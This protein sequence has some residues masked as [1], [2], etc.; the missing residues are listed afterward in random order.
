MKRSRLGAKLP[1][2]N[3]PKLCRVSLSWQAFAWASTSPSYGDTVLH[4]YGGCQPPMKRPTADAATLRC[5]LSAR[6]SWLCSEVSIFIQVP[7]GVRAKQLDISIQPHH[8]RV[9]IQGL[10]PYLD[11]RSW[12]GHGCRG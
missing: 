8:L 12:L 6:P 2:Q 1:S 10:P 5:W 11:V 7:E 9:G 3:H 4:I